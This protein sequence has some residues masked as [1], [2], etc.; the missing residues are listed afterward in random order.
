MLLTGALAATAALAG[1]GSG[2]DPIARPL[3]PG[4]AE[5]I[6]RR[7]SAARGTAV[8][9]W[10]VMPD[11][12]VAAYLP[13]CIVLFDA[14]TTVLDLPGLGLA[15]F[16]GEAVERGASP[17]AL[18][19]VTPG[20]RLWQ[21][22]GTD[23]PQLM[24]RREV[25]KW[26]ADRGF[27]ATRIALLGWSAGA[28][29]ALALAQTYPRWARAVAALSPTVTPGDEVF[30]GVDRL[31]GTPVGVWCG[32]DDPRQ[33]DV[34]AFE[35][36][37]PDGVAAGGHEPGRHDLGYWTRT[38]PAALDFVGSVL[39]AGSLPG[40]SAGGAEVAEGLGRAPVQRNR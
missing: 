11:G 27:D 28:S 32:S 2:P 17:F 33:A 13:V 40:T 20:P 30:G 38:M 19:A 26:C 36:A 35:A 4:G 31:R 34:R 1:C 6:Q 10:T 3:G 15:G 9:L 8:D 24:I 29:G 12:Y 16:L 21:P 5:R 39:A 25:P 37:L 18:V 22:A 23:N 14:P 7:P